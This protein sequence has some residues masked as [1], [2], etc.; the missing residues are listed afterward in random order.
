[1]VNARFAAMASHYL[2]DTD[3]CNV[4]S[5]WEKGVVEKNVQDSRRRIWQEAGQRRFG[6][7]A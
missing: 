1:V 3:F 2:F 7:F 5:G 6:S 4:A